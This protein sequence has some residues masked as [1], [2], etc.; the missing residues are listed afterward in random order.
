MVIDSTR[1]IFEKCSSRAQTKSGFV[2]SV[3]S[4]LNNVKQDCNNHPVSER[5]SSYKELLPG[6]SEVRSVF[7]G[8]GVNYKAGEVGRFS[9]YMTCPLSLLMKLQLLMTSPFC[10]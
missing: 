5:I 1:K 4:L 8:E 6:Q 10:A 2:I 3:H 9:V 7:Q